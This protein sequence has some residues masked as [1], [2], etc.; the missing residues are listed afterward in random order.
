M[1][2]QEQSI[3]LPVKVKLNESLVISTLLC[4]I[5]FTGVCR[6]YRQKQKQNTYCM[7]PSISVPVTQRKKLEAGSNDH[8]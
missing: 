5:S 1:E 2:K 3:T 4:V 8:L 6:G 7:V